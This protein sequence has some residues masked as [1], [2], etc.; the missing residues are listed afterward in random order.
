MKGEYSLKC[1]ALMNEFVELE[2]KKPTG[3]TIVQ[4]CRIQ[5]SRLVVEFLEQE[6]SKFEK[7]KTLSMGKSP[8]KPR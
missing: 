2:S 4:S 6:L 1:K 8:A 5:S 7:Q 3:L